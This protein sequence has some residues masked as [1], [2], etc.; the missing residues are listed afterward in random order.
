ML[1]GTPPL[2]GMEECQQNDFPKPLPFPSC[3]RNLPRRAAGHA[4]LEGIDRV[5]YSLDR[6]RKALESN[7]RHDGP[8]DPPRAA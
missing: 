5:S 8:G 4:A 1:V 3:V 2:D 6:L 7:D